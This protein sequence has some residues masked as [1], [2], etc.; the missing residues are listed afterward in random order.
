MIEINRHLRKFFFRSILRRYLSTVSD[1]VNFRFKHCGRAPRG[2]RGVKRSKISCQIRFWQFEA[3]IF[4][5]NWKNAKN[6][7]NDLKNLCFWPYFGS[8]LSF[9]WILALQT[10]KFVFST[11]F[12]KFWHPGHPWERIRSGDILVF[13]LLFKNSER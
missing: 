11:K 1:A 12:Q 10:N 3:L 4:S 13:V 8:L 9:S 5:Q 2:V 7:K 6:A